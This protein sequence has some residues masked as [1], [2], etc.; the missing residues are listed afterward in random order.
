MSYEH[1]TKQVED[2]IND[3]G[4]LRS[5]TDFI[6][7]L[8]SMDVGI[9]IAQAYRDDYNSVCEQI[10]LK[11]SS[12]AGWT[13]AIYRVYN[14]ES[15]DEALDAIGINEA[16]NVDLTKELITNIKA[17]QNLQSKNRSLSRITRDEIL[18]YTNLD[19]TF[20]QITEILDTLAADEP[21]CKIRAAKHKTHG[22]KYKFGIVTIGD[23]HLNEL[24]LDIDELTNRYSFDVAAKRLKQGIEHSKTLMTANGITDVLFV[25]GGDI[26]NSSRREDERLH[27]ESTRGVSTLVG[28]W[29]MKQIIDDLSESF[30]VA[31]T[32]VTG[33]ESRFDFDNSFSALANTD[34]FDFLIYHMTKS[35]YHEKNKRVTFLDGVDPKE[36]YLDIKGFKLLVMHGENMRAK[37]VDKT[38][39]KCSFEGKEVN[40]ILSYHFHSVE[41]TDQHFRVGSICGGNSYS[42]KSLQFYTRASMGLVMVDEN[43]GWDGVRIDV[44]DAYKY[45]PTYSI[46]DTFR[47]YFISSE[48]ATPNQL[49]SE[50]TLKYDFK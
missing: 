7:L 40:L 42:V 46:P 28:S 34:N 18:S 5:A 2:W 41:M 30:N 45:E 36:R 32:Y 48:Y 12:S 35:M 6:R 29:L 14:A 15:L 49:F 24:I 33:N 20:K 13:S 9:D 39:S 11:R 27:S 22:K 44:Q 25:M 4:S 10:K 50:E 47:K 38:L 17:K 23:V 37:H 19:D 26:V 8:R 1:I 21:K 31:V 16:S 43:N 3:G